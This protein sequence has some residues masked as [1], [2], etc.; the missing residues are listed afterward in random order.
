MP[1]PVG[2]E[3]PDF[4][5]KDQNNQVVRLRDF[6]GRKAVL[7][8]FYPFTFTGT[9]RGELTAVRDNLDAFQNET[10]QVLAVSVDSVYSHKVWAV[11]ERFDFP[12]LADFWPHGEVARSYQVFNDEGGMA[13]RGTF[14]IDP[15]GVIQFSE[16]IGPGESRDVKAWLAA[17]DR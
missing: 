1:L 11:Q 6:R 8:V 10:V 15:S 7:L 3:A 13:N 17:L 12:L 4:T 9:C 5:L 2:A 14:L 16:M